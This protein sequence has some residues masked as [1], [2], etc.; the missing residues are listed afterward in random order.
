MII[1]IV[2]KVILNKVHHKDRLV[3]WS[4]QQQLL[5]PVTLCQKLMVQVLKPAAI[6]DSTSF[7][8]LPL[9]ASQKAAL[10]DQC[11]P[12]TDDHRLW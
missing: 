8:M 11:S 10:Q 9:H 4:N 3:N 7:P 6:F 12:C 1:N 5:K 2:I